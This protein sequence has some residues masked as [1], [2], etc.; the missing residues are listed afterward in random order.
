MSRLSRGD[1]FF[2]RGGHSLLGA[3]VTTLVQAELGV[4]VPLRALFEAPTLAAFAAH[5]AA[6]SGSGAMAAGE[7]EI[8]L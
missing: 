4:G 2:M 3:R 8:V 5:V 7:E 1:D 6:L